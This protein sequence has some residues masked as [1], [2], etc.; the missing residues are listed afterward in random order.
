MVAAAEEDFIDGGPHGDAR[1]P[2]AGQFPCPGADA[3]P[4]AVHVDLFSA[5]IEHRG[6]A[7]ARALPVVGVDV[8]DAG[9]R[10]TVEVVF[11]AAVAREDGDRLVFDQPAGEGVLLVQAFM[12][13]QG[14]LGLEF[15]A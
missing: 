9:I 10:R 4:P 6:V 3:V 13:V 11:E 8:V 2:D 7:H 12:L 1:Q 5:D 15:L 14:A